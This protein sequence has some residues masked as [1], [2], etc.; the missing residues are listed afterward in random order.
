VIALLD[1]ARRDDGA[2]D[3]LYADHVVRML[4]VHVLRH[5]ATRASSGTAATRSDVPHRADRIDRVRDLIEHALADDLSLERLAAEAGIGAHGFSVAFR[6]AVGV[7]PHR[8]VVQRRVERAKR[9]LREGDLPI[10]EV[11]VRTGFASQSHLAVTFKREVGA[12]P[13]EYQR[14]R[15]G[16]GG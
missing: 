1:A 11:A 2:A 14:R 5:H 10:A 4:A 8:Y 16:V 13:G 7:S 3:G 12:T 9:L 15:G 6:R